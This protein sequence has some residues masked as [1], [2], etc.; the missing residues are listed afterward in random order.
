[1]AKASSGTR[2]ELK[3]L[4][5]EVTGILDGDGKPM[6]I[7]IRPLLGT[8]EDE[9]LEYAVEYARAHKAAKIERGDPIYDKGWSLAIIARAC[10]DPDTPVPRER[11]FDRGEEQVKPLHPL[12]IE[13]LGSM[14]EHWC[15]MTSPMKH[16]MTPVE[17]VAFIRDAVADDWQSRFLSLAPAMRA[18]SWRFMGRLAVSFPDLTSLV[19]RCFPDEPMSSSD[20]QIPTGSA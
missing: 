16:Q 15:S 9:A 10:L 19:S 20:P 4:D 13:R 2:A 5:A 17:L 3:E 6:P 14:I 11:F 18:L 8:E 12:E 7:K 1:M